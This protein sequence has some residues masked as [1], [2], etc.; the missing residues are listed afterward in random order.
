VVVVAGILSGPAPAL[1]SVKVDILS[2]LKDGATL[3]RMGGAHLRGWLVSVQVAM[4]MVLLVEAALFAQSEDRTLHAS[5]GYLPYRVLVAQIH[6]PNSTTLQQATV[7]LRAMADRINGLPGVRAVAFSDGLP[8]M[9]RKTV[10]LTPPARADATQP[11]SGPVR[12]VSWFSRDSRR[13]VDGRDL[14]DSDGSA[15]VVSQ[16]LAN[17][18]WPH[19]NAVGQSLPLPGGAIPVVGVARD[20][21]PMRFGG[22]DN[23]AAYS[24]RPVDA[25]NNSMSV[26]FDTASSRGGPAVRAALRASDPHA[27]VITRQLQA[28]ID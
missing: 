14:Q 25:H 24:L 8:M 6:F 18:F 13:R 16:R 15:V 7:R 26:R 10:E 4:S 21:A 19:Q 9:Q 12:R 2:S 17:L 28:W 3:S 22:S 27:F 11:A 1:E 5:P 20:V 23:P